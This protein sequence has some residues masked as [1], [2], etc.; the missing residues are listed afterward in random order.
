MRDKRHE[1]ALGLT[2]YLVRELRA[3]GRTVLHLSASEYARVLDA[4]NVY[5]RAFADY[6]ELGGIERAARLYGAGQAVLRAR[7]IEVENEPHEKDSAA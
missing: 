5:A 7:G 1:D 4:S 6:V 3:T 2:G